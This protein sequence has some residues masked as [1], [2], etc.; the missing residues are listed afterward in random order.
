MELSQC[1]EHSRLDAEDQD[2]NL[3]SLS[4]IL[5]CHQSLN[6]AADYKQ[7]SLHTPQQI[8]AANHGPEHSQY[9]DSQLRR[10]KNICS[11]RSRHMMQQNA[12]GN[13]LLLT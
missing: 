5:L 1:A 12:A 9:F 2:K 8:T 6:N 3:L 11:T 10:D 13:Y 4:G 7:R